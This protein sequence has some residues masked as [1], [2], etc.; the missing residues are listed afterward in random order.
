MDA[1]G[2]AISG[3]GSEKRTFF[4]G[5]EGVFA[6]SAGMLLKSSTGSILGTCT[7]STRAVLH[8]RFL[9]TAKGL[10]SS[11]IVSSDSRESCAIVR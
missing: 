8:L 3:P 4:L 2:P 1:E 6:G 10:S 5:L 7:G 11:T 9:R